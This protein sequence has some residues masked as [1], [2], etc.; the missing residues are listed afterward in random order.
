LTALGNIS[1][2]LL[3]FPIQHRGEKFTGEPSQQ[4]VW[5]YV[6]GSLLTALLLF[7]VGWFLKYGMHGW[8]L[9]GGYM[10]T[11]YMASLWIAERLWRQRQQEIIGI[12]D[13]R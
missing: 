8:I 1:S 10:S 12:L 6:G 3:P 13:G 5:L 11:L 2:I 4:T 7:P 9:A